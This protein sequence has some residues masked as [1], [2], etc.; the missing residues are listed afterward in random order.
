MGESAWCPS[1]APQRVTT[2]LS[3]YVQ[4]RRILS[5]RCSCAVRRGLWHV[6]SRHAL[7]AQSAVAFGTHYEPKIVVFFLNATPAPTADTLCAAAQ[8]GRLPPA[9]SPYASAAAFGT[10]HGPKFPSS[11]CPSTTPH[12]RPSSCYAV[13][14]RSWVSLYR[15]PPTQL[16]A[17]TP[18]AATPHRGSSRRTARRSKLAT[19]LFNATQAPSSCYATLFERALYS[20]HCSHTFRYAL[21]YASSVSRFTVP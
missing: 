5:I 17:H 1:T 20:R 3:C 13:R 11:W 19:S 14:R 15:L 6:Y 8:N 21:W 10:H 4:A 9:L 12:W 2:G 7:L 16:T 18:P